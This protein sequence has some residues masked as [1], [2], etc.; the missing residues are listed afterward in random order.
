ML[1]RIR[2]GLI[3]LE[4][5]EDTCAL[6]Q[7][8]C[9]KTKEYKSNKLDAAACIVSHTH[10]LFDSECRV[11]LSQKLVSFSNKPPFMSELHVVTNGFTNG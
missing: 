4:A 7:I 5:R 3:C 6:P 1:I 10:V 8:Q 9:D 11:C 2:T